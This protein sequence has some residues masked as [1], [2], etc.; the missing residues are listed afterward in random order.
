M[1]IKFWRSKYKSKWIMD[2][3]VVESTEPLSMW[4]MVYARQ[5]YKELGISKGEFEKIKYRVRTVNG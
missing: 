1:M 2:G 5:R 4:A 3:I